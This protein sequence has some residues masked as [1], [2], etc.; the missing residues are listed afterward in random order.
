MDEVLN[1]HLYHALFL[2]T[3]HVLILLLP[4]TVY[5]R[6]QGIGLKG[7]VGEW[8]QSVY[9]NTNE[10]EKVRYLFVLLLLLVLC[11]LRCL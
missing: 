1:V 10:I 6:Y 8:A 7:P 3:V 2:F 11:N 5:S 9:L 4:H